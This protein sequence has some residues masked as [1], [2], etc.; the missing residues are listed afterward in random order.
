MVQLTEIGGIVA[1]LMPA[2]YSRPRTIEDLVDQTVGRL[3]DLIGIQPPEALVARWDGP[4]VG[5][6]TG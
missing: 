4:P 6:S 1:P 3:L 5:A 2:F